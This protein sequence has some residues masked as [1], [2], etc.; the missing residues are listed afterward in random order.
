MHT[1]RPDIRTREDLMLLMEAFYTQAIPD[2]VIGHYFTEVTRLDLPS[3][4]PKLV[5]F[6]DQ[7]LF[8]TVGYQGN[9]MLVHRKLHAQSA[10]EE[11]HFERWLELF[12]ATVDARFQGE[13]AELIKEK[14]RSIAH[15]MIYKIVDQGIGGMR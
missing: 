5:A 12:H 4:L 1:P 3:H 15:L 10:F 9:P 14:A 11:S 7:V 6:W 13:K 8:G 2:P